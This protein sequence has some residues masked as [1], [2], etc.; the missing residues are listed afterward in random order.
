[1]A[2]MQRTATT[3][4][5][6]TKAMRGALRLDISGHLYKEI[7]V[8]RFVEDVW[9]LPSSQIE[10]IKSARLPLRKDSLEK[11]NS[12]LKEHSHKESELHRPFREISTTLLK[13]ICDQLGIGQD[14]LKTWFWDKQGAGVLKNQFTQRKPDM[15][16]FFIYMLKDESRLYDPEDDDDYKQMINII[17]ITWKEVRSVI[18]FKRKHHD[19]KAEQSPSRDIHKTAD[20]SIPST[21][22]SALEGSSKRPLSSDADEQEPRDRKR[23]YTDITEDQLQ[24][25]SYALECL[26]VSSRHYATGIFIDKSSVSLWY[27]DRT[28][29]I[30]TVNFDFNEESGAS[31]LGIALFALSQCNMT[32]AGFDPNL[33]TFVEPEPGMPIMALNILALE[34]PQATEAKLCY[35]FPPHTS[36]VQFVFPILEVLS[37]YRGIIGRGTFVASV[38]VGVIGKV[39][40]KSLHV[41]KISWQYEKRKHEGEIVDHLHK[42]VGPYW[43]RR[44]PVIAFHD[45]YTAKEV[46]LPRSKMKDILEIM[47]IPVGGEPIQNRDLHILASRHYK[48]L[49]EAENV[50]E[51]KCVFLDC[52]E[53]HFHAYETGR[54]LHRDIS[55]S[56]LMIWR[57][58]PGVSETTS[59]G[60]LNDFDMASELASDDDNVVIDKTHNLTGTLPFMAFGLLDKASPPSRHF[61]RYDLESFYHILVWAAIHYELSKGRRRQTPQELRFWNDRSHAYNEKISGLH[62]LRQIAAL[63]LPEFEGIWQDWVIPLNRMFSKAILEE[64][65]A[66]DKRDPTYDYSTCAGKITFQKFME[67]IKETPRGD[68]GPVD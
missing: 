1:M 45:V 35:K 64:S 60:I 19:D 24:L 41:L 22:K 14:K 18:E 66:L 55:E 8:E 62:H 15:L 21:L 7:P 67:A 13:Q 31:S 39:L 49:W 16:D 3:S 20:P 44:L 36:D 42:A 37:V 50:E 59:I 56:N 48:N 47:P 25:A 10:A 52:L 12:I 51:F 57:E 63:R 33:Y 68:L 43:K 23:R 4:D 40:Q 29:V 32:Q 17:D 58:G 30:R 5:N 9:G 2:M 11:Y 26:G 54:V 61:Y 65:V 46:N 28:A 6:T 53:C 27:Y 38:Y 34:K